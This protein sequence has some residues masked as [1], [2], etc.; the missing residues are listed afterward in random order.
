YVG[1]EEMEYRAAN[2]RRA[3]RIRT[4]GRRNE[5]R[6]GIGHGQ[7]HRRHCHQRKVSRNMSKA[8]NV[9]IFA[10]VAGFFIQFDVPSYVLKGTWMSEAE[11]IIGRPH[12][13]GD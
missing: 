7:C 11:A 3:F 4:V 13:S 5:T 8:R 10:L 9:I 1:I 2:R 6:S 12:T